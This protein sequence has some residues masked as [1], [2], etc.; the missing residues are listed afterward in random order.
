MA[1][2]L[3]GGQVLKDALALALPVAVAPTACAAPFSIPFR[4]K[5]TELIFGG[6]GRAVGRPQLMDFKPIMVPLCPC[7]LLFS[8]LLHLTQ[9]CMVENVI[10]DLLK[11]WLPCNYR[12]S[13]GCVTLQSE[14]M[15]RRCVNLTPSTRVSCNWDKV[16]CW[17]HFLSFFCNSSLDSL[18]D[19]LDC[20][21]STIFSSS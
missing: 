12:R 9:S 3:L 20:I 17:K 19:R 8:I 6:S 13:I 4:A 2:R 21:I 10:F 11:L 15:K 16:R 5:W 14:V 1:D 7:L 18:F